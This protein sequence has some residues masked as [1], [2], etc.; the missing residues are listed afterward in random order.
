MNG[1]NLEN[2]PLEEYTTPSPCS[3][4]RGD[5]IK[6]V[7]KL[8]EENEIRHLPVVDNSGAPVGVISDRDLA[9]V[10]SFAFKEDM[11]A[12]D[13]MS[14]DP[15]TAHVNGSLLEAV[16]SMSSQKIGSIIVTD[17]HGSVYGI[18]TNTDALNAL[19]EVL[20]GDVYGERGQVRNY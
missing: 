3:V 18:F 9:F 13:L 2:I 5:G 11:T 6:K 7:I 16:Y 17:D 20:R 10:R 12:S 8:M 19:I 4:K 1:Q 14:P 15:V